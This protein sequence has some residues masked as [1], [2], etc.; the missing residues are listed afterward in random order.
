IQWFINNRPL[1]AGSRVKTLNEFGYCVL[2]I[3]PVYPEDSGDIVCKALNK[4][5][6][7]V[8]STSLQ[9]EGKE[10]IIT[11]SQLPSAM[12]GAQTRIDE[13]ENRRP[14][15]IDQ[16][17]VEHGPPK[18]TTQLQSL[19][20]LREGS[21]I[22]LDVQVEPVADPRLKIEWFHNGNPVGHSSR[23]KAIHDFGFV[24]LE[25]SPAEP[26]DTGT[27]TCK[28][29]N[30]HGSDEVS[31]EINVSGDSGVIYEWVA[32]GERRER[33]NQLDEWINRPRDALEEAEME[34]DAPV[35][36]EQLADLGDLSECDAASFMCVLEPIGDPTMKIVWQHNGGAIPHSNR[37]QMSNDFG[38]I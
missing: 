22:H 19:P 38:V 13:I 21:L 8:T 16:P 31:T 37:I 27:W 17:A 29:T 32:P 26:Q 1:F 28:A 7:A 23:M 2:E 3:S 35:F 30:E 10:G 4:V 15:E 20:E 34:F 11:Q 6:E 5:G 36:T 9:V 14:Q 24:V 12:S 33:I 25:L 18:F